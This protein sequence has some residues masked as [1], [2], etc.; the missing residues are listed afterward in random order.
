MH[1]GGHD[2]DHLNVASVEPYGLSD[3]HRVAREAPFPIRFRQK[4]HRPSAA[5]IFLFREHPAKH[6]LHTKNS[7][8]I[9]GNSQAR[10]LLRIAAARQSKS[11]PSD[12]SD[13][14]K[15]LGLALPIQQVRIRNSVPVPTLGKGLVKRGETIGFGEPRGVQQRAIDDAVDG[16]IGADAKRQCKKHG[17]G[18]ARTAAK[19]PYG[20]QEVLKY[21]S[22]HNRSPVSHSNCSHPFE[23]A[24]LYRT[25][26]QHRYSQTDVRSL[27]PG[28]HPGDHRQ[29]GR[30]CRVGR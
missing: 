29:A 17:E 25:Y 8:Q 30:E 3:D 15:R 23:E 14:F 19:R 13:C 9:R 16:R 20:E 28:R 1:A 6:R 7:K 2:P 21:V 5:L 10:D 24:A 18:E 4:S 11:V 12:A 26:E 22:K 27:R